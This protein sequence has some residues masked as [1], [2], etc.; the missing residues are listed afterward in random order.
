MNNNK[1]NNSNPSP[2]NNVLIVGEV[3]IDV[4][5]EYNAEV[6]FLPPIISE[7]TSNETANRTTLMMP[8]PIDEDS[9]YRWIGLILAAKRKDL[10]RDRDIYLIF[11]FIGKFAKDS[12]FSWISNVNEN[13]TN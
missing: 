11:L 8:I 6:T 10:I 5:N 3:K 2:A 4:L 1:D 12:A 13:D 7:V 9:V